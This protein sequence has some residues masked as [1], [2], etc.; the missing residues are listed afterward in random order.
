MERLLALAGEGFPRVLGRRG[1]ALLLEWIPGKSLAS[2][3][4]I[5]PDVLRRCGERLGALHR[6]RV[7]P[8]LGVPV[9][10]VDDLR[11]RLAQH[12]AALE[13]AG[14]LAPR[15]ARRAVDLAR[16]HAPAQAT[17]GLVH[18]DFCAEN[19]V[20]DGFAAPV[21]IDNASLAL[22][23]HDFD[24]GRTWARWPMA[25]AGRAHFA[26]G[27]AKERSLETFLA[28][29]PFWACCALLGSAAKRVR[30]RTGGEEE[31]LDR[32]RRLI[33]LAERSAQALA[34]AFWAL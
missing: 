1:D 22:G 27:Y 28:Q 17:V 16:E 25:R 8:E 13:R 15:L 34:S 5:P 14:A 3:A 9:L 33:E 6:L 31:P 26:E 12:A 18:R 20:L 7:A 24:L 4:E 11:E 30:T 29:L 21:C 10:G 32:L 2:L 19:I 23:P